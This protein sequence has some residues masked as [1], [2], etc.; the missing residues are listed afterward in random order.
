LIACTTP[1]RAKILGPLFSA[2]SVTILAA[3][4]TFGMVCS[5]FGISFA[6]QR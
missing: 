6:G 1:I 4:W 2:A 3:A 5:D